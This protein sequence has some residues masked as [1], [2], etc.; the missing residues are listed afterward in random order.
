MNRLG[1]IGLPAPIC[2]YT[3]KISLE[4]YM[5]TREL[6]DRG[7]RQMVIFGYKPQWPLEL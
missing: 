6:G 7:E 5:P 1:T 2:L 4:G 3:H